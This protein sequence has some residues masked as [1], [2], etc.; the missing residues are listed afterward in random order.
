MSLYRYRIDG[1]FW[2]ETSRTLN[3]LFFRCEEP[4]EP[5]PVSGPVKFVGSHSLEA[6]AVDNDGLESSVITRAFTT[7]NIAPEVHVT[8]P[9]PNPSPFFPTQVGTSAT[10][11][12]EGHDWD[13][14]FSDR[15]IRYKYKLLDLG[16]PSNI[17]YLSNPDLLRQEAANLWAGW[18]STD[19]GSPSV[20]FTNLTPTRSYLF[21]VVGFDEAG[22][23]SAPFALRVN[24]LW[25][26][27]IAGLGA[28]MAEPGRGIALSRP[29]PNPARQLARLE[30]NLPREGSIGLTVHDTNGRHIRTLAQGAAAAG[31]QRVT[32]NLCDDR[33]NRV[34]SG[35]YF[36]RLKVDG[37][38]L[39][40]KVLVVPW[41][42][43]RHL[44]RLFALDLRRDA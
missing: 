13:G 15:P 7:Y 40:Q 31:G 3:Q 38:S 44:S 36:V 14:F 27:V 6:K 25:L 26:E 5:I 22:A 19:S 16:D 21:S 43:L 42:R 32:W 4:L 11:D 41:L 37:E 39:T 12:W 1:F 2:I 17:K 10:I 8:S 18:D 30:L 23:H 29:T 20:Q 24:T 35:L 9:V 28:P 33:G 34:A